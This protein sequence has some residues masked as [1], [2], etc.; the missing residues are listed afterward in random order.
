MESNEISSGEEPNDMHEEEVISLDENQNNN[1]KEKNMTRIGNKFYDEDTMN[2]ITIVRLTQVGIEPS[3]I[4]KMLKISRSL[5][6]KWVNYAKRPMK[7][8]GRPPKFNTEHKNFLYESAEGKLTIINKVSSRNLAV[9]FEEEFGK[10]I[11]YSYV[12]KLLFNKFG[13]PYRGINT[14]LLKE[15]HIKQRLDF[16]EFIIEK[17]IKAKDIIFTDEC[18]VILFPKINPKINIIRFNENDKKNI[19]SYEVNKKRS[20]FRPKFEVGIMIAGGI[21]RYGLSNLVF[22]SGTMNNF[23]YK[24]FLLFIK[25]DMEEMKKKNKLNSNLLFQQDNASCHKSR[26]TL[27]ALEVIFGDDKI[28]WPANSPDL[29]PIETVWAILKQELSKKKILL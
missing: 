6:S 12:N 27:E 24:Q 21:S 23:A 17:G 22:C 14:V 28:W 5:L 26:E 8:M 13:R 16:S 7:K 11:S 29:S 3:K 19:H 1:K 20:F 4:R 18:R 25:Q 15:D 2:R 9:K 10:K